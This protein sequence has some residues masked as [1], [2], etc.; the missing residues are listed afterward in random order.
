MNPYFTDFSE[1]LNQIFPGKK[2]QK[3]SVNTSN[4]CPNRDG[5]LGVGGCIYCNNRSFT[6]TYC[7]ESDSVIAQIEKG[8][9]FFG[10]KYKN[11]E[12]LAYFQSFTSTYRQ[13]PEDFGKL[14]HQILRIDDIAGI[15]IGTR[16]D[17]L[18]EQTIEMLGEF[19]KLQPIFVELGVES[20]N[21]NTLRLINRGHS[22]DC[23]I[24]TVAKLKAKK[25]H[26]GVHLIAG[27][28]GE[29]KPMMHDTIINVCGLGVNSIKL[30]Q[31]QV[32]KDTPLHKEWREG[33]LDI[34]LW[35]LEEYLN[36]CIE[37]VKEVP[38]SIA[39]ERF[40]SS[41]PLSMVVAP[42]W[43]IKN[44]EFTNLLLNKLKSNE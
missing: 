27:L 25:L 35:D 7:F 43:G 15:V 28:P 24:Q 34:K 20:M 11:I 10:R 3:L 37:V 40:V 38:K 33:K 31:L 30:H 14:L 18:D 9:L 36:F 41:A 12:Y 22:A 2:I 44:Y 16:P 32:L 39:I 26:I 42:K 1:Y 21:D 6:P 4:G 19:N 5:T 8:K 13:S 23:V 17:C 29:D